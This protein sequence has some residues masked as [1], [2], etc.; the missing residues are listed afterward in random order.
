[1]FPYF[2]HSPHNDHSACQKAHWQEHKLT[3][4]SLKDATWT[5]F[6]FTLQ[7]HLDGQPTDVYST[8][9]NR[10]DNLSAA[11]K[12]TK[13]QHPTDGVLPN[14]H[15]DQ[16]FLLKVQDNGQPSLMVYDR[17]RD[18][19]AFFYRPESWQAEG[20]KWKELKDVITVKGFHPDSIRSKC[21]FWAKRTG[22]W[23]VS[24]A[25]DRVP[26]QAIPW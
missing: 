8:I 26:D 2:R 25:L 5:P 7:L 24:L 6:I 15:G 12:K 14:T 18:L 9:I 23:E 20:G 1:M 13:I 21:Y 19:S 10:R 17:A 16:P 3:C 22:D 4:K 11:S